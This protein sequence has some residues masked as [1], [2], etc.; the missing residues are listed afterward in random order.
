MKIQPSYLLPQLPEALDGLAE[1]ALDLRWSWSHGT[2]SLWEK[3]DADLWAS[4]RNPW[5]VLQNIDNNSL[6]HLA[7]DANFLALLQ[8][9]LQKRR[10]QHYGTSWFQKEYPQAPCARIAYFSMEFGVSEALPIYSGGL[11]ILAGDVLKTAGDL[12]IPLVGIGILWQQGYFRQSLDDC[13]RQM[14]LYPYNDPT[15][16]PITPVRDAEGQWLRLE[17]DFPGRTLILRAWQAQVGTIP[18]YLLDSNDPLNTPADRGITAELYGGGPEMR[19]QQ[20]ICLGIGGWMLLRRLGITPEICHLNEGHAAMVILARIHSH[21]QDTG[22]DFHCAL[23]ATRA[24]NVFTTHTP[25]AAGF[26]RFT[27]ALVRRY[28]EGSQSLFGVDPEQI[29]SLGRTHPK[30]SEEPF[31]V[32]WLAIRGSQV[33]N[34]VSALHG[35]VSRHLFQELFPRWPAQ[36]VPVTHVTN[37]IHVPSWDS[38]AADTLWT[39]ACGHDRWNLSRAAIADAITK[40]SDTDLWQLRSKAR[41]QLIEFARAR[42]TQ[43]LAMAHRPAEEIAAAQTVLDPNTLTV[44]FARRFTAYKRTNL[45]LTQPERLAALLRNPRHPMQLLLAGKAHPKDEQG[46]AMIQEW[47]HFLRQH[48]DLFH[49]VVFLADY[50]MLVAAQLVQGMDVWINTP[51][52]PWEASGTSGMKVLVNGGLNCSE[53]D[54]WWAEA[55]SPSYGWA[56]GDRQEHDADPNWD[57]QEAEAL[58]TL[59]EEEIA[60]LFYQGRTDAGCP[61]AWVSRMRAS[62]GELTQ[63]F[64]SHRMMQEYVTKLYLPAAEKVAQRKNDAVVRELCRWQELLQQH[65]QGLRFG[66]LYRQ[67]DEQTLQFQMHVYLDDIG[68]NFIQVQLYADPIQDGEPEIHVMERGEALAGAVNGYTYRC[69]IPKTRPITD[70]TPRIIPYHPLASVP[71]ENPLILWYD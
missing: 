11:G 36:E 31:N 58:Y 50:D 70:F 67:E 10:Q 68:P 45:L 39:K 22:S 18:L 33:V 14:E 32:A 44:G 47:T 46:K 3:I 38:E 23:N 16:L 19:L 12:G 61:T 24:G 28:L 57:R 71:L 27:P 64:S 9:Q 17:L 41:Q 21:M 48:P 60:P 13:G 65:W 5:L 55:Y 37:G 30:D 49:K 40:I 51:R 42:L 66:Q 29:L 62:M 1:L 4:S 7:N 20:E 35:Q 56:L 59:L 63:R 26:D 43:Q 34:G 54:G 15:Q 25:V 8:E 69:S 2:D 52:R 6:N 53:L